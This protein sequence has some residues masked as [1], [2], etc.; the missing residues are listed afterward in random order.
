M[1]RL[2]VSDILPNLLSP[3]QALRAATVKTLHT[4]VDT[5]YHEIASDTFLNKLFVNHYY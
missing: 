4:V 1:S 2:T 5:F 3:R